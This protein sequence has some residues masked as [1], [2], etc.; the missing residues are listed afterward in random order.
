MLDWIVSLDLS[1]VTSIL[2]ISW[3]ILRHTIRNRMFNFQC[4]IFQCKKPS[5]CHDVLKFWVKTYVSMSIYKTPR[6]ARIS[7]HFTRKTWFAES[8]NLRWNICFDS[9]FQHIVAKWRSLAL[10]NFTLN[11]KHSISY[12][13]P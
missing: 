13:V 5:F 6:T 1:R 11:V 2:L 12:G 10:K 4:E 7:E 8:C 9:E 3:P